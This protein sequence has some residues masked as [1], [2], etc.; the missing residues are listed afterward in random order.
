MP[1]RTSNPFA[2]ILEDIDPSKNPFVQ[3]L[4]DAQESGTL[5][6]AFGPALKTLPGRWRATIC[7][8]Q[9]ADLTTMPLI[10]EIGCHNGHTLVEMAR[11]HPNALFLGID[12]TFKRV[13]N[14][15]TRACE[16]GL[17]N[18][19]AILAN[20]GGVEHLFQPGEVSG[21]VTFFPDPW[22]KKKHTHYRL[23]QPHFFPK[24]HTALEDD[25]F[26]WLKTDHEPYFTDASQYAQH[27]GFAPTNTC[28]VLGEQDF[29]SS[30]Q[31]R[32]TIAGLPTFSQRWVHPSS[33]SHTL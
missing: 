1:I 25:G 33:S 9:A 18:V 3:R 2:N 15:A 26:L 7:Q 12:I 32:F 13:I 14:T 16:A 31:K 24:I 30:F 10:V 4:I 27:S 19:F 11:A 21:F 5:P 28:K 22:K 29:S 8:D 23:Y 20:A 17:T 6:V